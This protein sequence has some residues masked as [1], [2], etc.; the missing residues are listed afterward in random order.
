MVGKSDPVFLQRIVQIALVVVSFLTLAAGY[1]IVRGPTVPDRV[2]GLDT[3]GTNVVAISVLFALQTNRG[4][5]VTVAL[6]LAIIG[7]L[8]TIAA[9]RYIIEGDIIE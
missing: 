2:I 7:F 5:F 3:I 6:V 8:T 4:L 9:A 1:R